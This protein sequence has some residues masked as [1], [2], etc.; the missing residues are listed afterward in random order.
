MSTDQSLMETEALDSKS[1]NSCHSWRFIVKT[2]KTTDLQVQQSPPP[3][4]FILYCT[5]QPVVCWCS[6]TQS[7]KPVFSAHS[8]LSGCCSGSAPPPSL[9]CPRAPRCRHRRRHR[10]A[11]SGR[12]GRRWAGVAGACWTAW[13]WPAGSAGAG[14]RSAASPDPAAPPSRS[15]SGSHSCCDAAGRVRSSGGASPSPRCVAV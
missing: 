7:V 5:P 2:P 6:N 14:R 4:L 10:P 9:H 8:P 15:R 11:L 3:S 13:L 1:T 12:P